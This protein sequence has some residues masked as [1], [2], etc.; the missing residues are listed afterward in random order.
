MSDLNG[1]FALRTPRDLLAKLEA[2]HAR[3]HR[4]D[5]TSVEAQY[6]AFD[7]FVTAEHLA[8]WV[9]EVT[10]VSKTKLRSYPDGALVSHIANGAKHFR[11]DTG[12]HSTAKDTRATVGAFQSNFQPGFTVSILIIELE[13]GAKERVLE[14]ADRVLRHWEDTA[15]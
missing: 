1:F 7:F 13:N 11:V 10:N 15:L 9:A 8:D 4:A 14:V 3:L 2:D 6:A 12:R 5:P